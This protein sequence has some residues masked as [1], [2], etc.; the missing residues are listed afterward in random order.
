MA[1]FI[2]PVEISPG[3]TGWQDVDVSAY[4]PV[5]A[6]G[7]IL[8]CVNS[9]ANNRAFG[10]RKNG[11]TDNRTSNL[12][13]VKH[14]WAAIGVDSNRI[15]EINLANVTDIDVYLVGY[16]TSDAVFFTNATDKS[17][18][19]TGSWYDIDISGD[20]GAYTAIGAIFEING[21]ASSYN[22]GLR[23]NG[24][25]DNRAAQYVVSHNCFGFVVGVDVSEICEGQIENVAVDFFLV[26]YIL[27]GST[28]NINA[29]DVSLA[30]INDWYDLS[31]LPAGSIGGYIE[32][33][34]GGVGQSYGLRKNGS[35]ENIYQSGKHP[36]GIVECDASL[37]IEGKISLAS[38]D[39]FL[40]GYINAVTGLVN[41]KTINGLAI[42][43]VK[44]INGLAVGSVKT[45]NSLS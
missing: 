29:T 22:Y 16:Y 13:A 27:S 39:F 42:A 12:Q 30:S 40:V 26:G 43:S 9:S 19:S 38:M 21:V 11:S 8:H 36:F 45:Y 1:Q 20:T 32:I 28:F 14:M 25:T 35:A 6:T 31:A 34:S 5:G 23:K 2:T 33:Y 18:G 37:I 3:S 15:L 41:I 7:V 10:L 17:L 24:S 4:V 44:T